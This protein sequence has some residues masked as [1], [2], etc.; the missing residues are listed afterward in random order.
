MKWLL[1]IPFVVLL[2]APAMAQERHEIGSNPIFEPARLVVDYQ[3]VWW[4]VAGLALIG[5][6]VCDVGWA[7]RYFLRGPK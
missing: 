4:V 2:A 3:D 5:V 1:A 6:I 7:A